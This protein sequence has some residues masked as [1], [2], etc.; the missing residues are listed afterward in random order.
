MLRTSRLDHQKTVSHCFCSDCPEHGKAFA[1]LGDLAHHACAGAPIDTYECL[2]CEVTFDNESDFEHHFETPGHDKAANESEKQ[3]QE[4]AVAAMQ[5]ARVEEINLWCEECQRSFCTLTGYK[6]HK[7]SHVHRASLVEL[8][9]RCGRE[10][11]LVSALLAHLESGKCPSGMTRD[12]LNAII[13]RFDTKRIV[14]MPEYV[15]LYAGSTITGSSRAS[16]APDDSASVLGVSLQSL[17]LDSSRASAT[18][19]IILTPN[20]SDAASVVSTQGG[21][22][23]TPDDSDLSSTDEEF[24]ATP[25]SSE[26][27]STLSYGGVILTPS[28]STVNSVVLA[29]ATGSFSDGELLQTPSGSSA[30]EV[31]G[32]WSF[33]NSS[34]MMTPASTSID[35]S[36]VATIRYD[37]LAK[38]WRCNKCD[39]TFAAKAHLQQH[40]NSAVHG[41]K[42]FHCP[43]D[44]PTDDDSH[45]RI[46]GF[47]TMSGL[48]AHVEAGSCN[49][50]RDTMKTIIGVMEKPMEKK[51]KASMNLLE[52]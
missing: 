28:A 10:F 27:A 49:G 32:E 48:T 36:S 2:A 22:I 9:C 24:I 13:Y 35:G 52:Q 23:L 33:M 46:R 39:R 41:P 8:E 3:Q 37:T 18:R 31:S 30:S 1:T 12:R 21:A 50:G 7:N 14:T 20:D 29:S 26:T 40:I 43:D 19:S 15:D 11:S 5:L 51:L 38:T 16:I 45:T 17:S 4:A 6:A 47:S 25:S 42:I 34:R 44:V